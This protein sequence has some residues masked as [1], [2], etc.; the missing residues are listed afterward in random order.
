MEKHIILEEKHEQKE[1][2][3]NKIEDFEILQ[4]IGKSSF[5]YISKVK[6][7]INK[8]IYTIKMIDF[9]TIENEKER[10]LSKDEREII[11][12]L[13][14]PHIIKCYGYFVE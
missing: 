12:K 11:N 4:N 3:G 5:G 14:S 6:S 7:K 13:V 1:F 2:I 10:Q 9:S 8:K